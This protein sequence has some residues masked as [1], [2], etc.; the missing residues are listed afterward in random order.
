M[1]ILVVGGDL[2]EN[3]MIV[4]NTYNKYD[5]SNPI[6]QMMMKGFARALSALVA[7]AAPASIHEVG[8]GEGYWVL[9]WLAAG[10]VARGS[11]FSREAISLARK[12]GRLQG[13]TSSPFA[14]TSIYELNA[15]RDGADLI[16]CCEVLEHLDRPEYALGM[17]QRIV[18]KYLIISVPRE[19]LWRAL[20]FLRVKYLAA[21]G[22]TPGH[23]Q[24]WSRRDFIC[25]IAQYFDIVE[26]RSPL[27]WTMLLCRPYGLHQRKVK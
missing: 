1:G 8:C 9:R 16:V 21:K 5:S 15:E 18:S 2:A 14:V 3:G 26:V 24:H 13:I 6:V 22:N 10:L 19:P 27:P 23:V 12:N 17:L 25:L 11:D 4:G 20:N 7:R